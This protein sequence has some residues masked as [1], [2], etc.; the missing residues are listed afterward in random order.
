MKFM[1]QIM[2]FY[3]EVGHLVIEADSIESARAEAEAEC[4]PH[5]HVGFVGEAYETEEGAVYW[6]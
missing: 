4:Q 5:E 1:A 6:A 3:D 2:R